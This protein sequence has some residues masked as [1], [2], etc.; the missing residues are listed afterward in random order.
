[1]TQFDLLSSQTKYKDVVQ[2]FYLPALQT[3]NRDPH[4]YGYAALRAYQA[5]GDESYLKIAEDIWDTGMTFTLTESDISAGKSPVKDA[6]LPSVCSNGATLVG[7][8]FYQ[9]TDANDAAISA[10]ATGDFLVLSASL[11]ATTPNQTYLDVATRSADF[12]RRHSYRGN[13]IFWNLIRAQDCGGEKFFPYETGAT[14]HGL[15]ILASVSQNTS[16]QAFVR[17][18]VVGMTSNTSWHDSSWILNLGD[19]DASEP[20]VHLMRGCL[21]AFNG[22]IAPT[23]FKSYLG[24]YIST[25]YNGVV[26]LAT[27]NGS[28]IY[29][30]TYDGPPVV[31]FSNNSQTG[32][33]GALLGGLTL[34]VANF[35]SAPSTPTGSSLVP[36][37]SSPS[38]NGTS[39]S[40]D[41]PQP[42]SHSTPVGAIVGGVLGGLAGALLIVGGIWLYIR[43][44]RTNAQG[45]L[46]ATP[47][48]PPAQGP[49]STKG[50]KFEG[51]SQH[52]SE[53]FSPQSMSR[54]SAI[55]TNPT[56]S[57][58]GPSNT[59]EMATTEALV[60]VL[61][62][63]LQNGEQW[64]GDE[65]PP[66]YPESALG[67][68][69][70]ASTSGGA[71]GVSI[72][73][74][75]TGK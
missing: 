61:Q 27:S 52:E 43:K 46:H 5:Y 42:K 7:G 74:K 68:R 75:R 36:T 16:T 23:D 2:K 39:S 26:D 60:S 12:L 20:R 49:I 25:Q 57:T 6:Q 67:Q 50:G 55:N 34:G 56:S 38:S 8:T 14:L 32:A 54:N 1:M 22:T 33:I 59:L 41:S 4:V 58:A 63:R 47:W 17:D 44:R 3:L 31:Q 65:A 30:L 24:S 64:N 71:R 19:N 10:G 40:S 72:G 29:G 11:A 48:D 18:I 70:E 15:S 53:P 62:R 21:E 73:R 35:T 45:S 37:D 13:G 69:R 66:A 51:E 9:G 28:N